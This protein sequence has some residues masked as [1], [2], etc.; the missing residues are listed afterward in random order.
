MC[1]LTE[2]VHEPLYDQRVAGTG[3]G[4]ERHA[5]GPEPN[6]GVIAVVKVTPDGG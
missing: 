3:E 5:P 1:V 6:T 4:V 2:S